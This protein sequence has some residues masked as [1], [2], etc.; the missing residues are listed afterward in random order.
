MNRISLVISDVDGTLVTP[1]KRLTE[2]SVQAVKSLRQHGI[3]FS[4][5][6]SRP[7]M[8]MR[9]LVEPL[10]LALPIGAFS[11][12]AIVSPGLDV[13]EQ[14]VIPEL[15]ARRS[16]EVMQRFGADVWLYTSDKW[17]VLNGNGDYVPREKR[18]IEADPVVIADFAPYF[19]EACKIVASSKDFARLAE[20][21]AATRAA[22]TAQASVVRSQAYY[23]D[24]TPPSVDKGT[25]LTVL[26]RRLA[27]QPDAIAVLG[28]MGNDLAMFAKAG[29]SIAMGNASEE[30]KRR[31]THVTAS[32]A[33]DGFAQAV[34]RYILDS[35]SRGKIA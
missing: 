18:T 12:G 9:M 23:L 5:V 35:A 7:P 3:A 27:I 13:I 28:D 24:V 30:V 8:G 10:S 31:A 19:G 15:A 11:G 33:D 20:C 16:I 25:F 26:S 32:N 6:S 34:A 21:E 29:L 14:H 17:L 1:D 4:I 22:V 2:A